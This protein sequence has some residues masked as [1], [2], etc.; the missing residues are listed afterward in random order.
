MQRS[1][2]LSLVAVVALAAGAAGLTL[3]LA[4]PAEG[5]APEP[6]FTGDAAQ[7]QADR[8]LRK[9]K[10][11]M[12]RKVGAGRLRPL[13]FKTKVLGEA[14]VAPVLQREKTPE[15]PPPQGSRLLIVTWDTVRADHVSSYG[16]FRETTPSFDALAAQ[17]VLFEN[18]I[19]PQS[20]TLP[21]HVSMFTGVH[22]DE[23][24]ITGNSASGARRFV[25]PDDL[26]PLARHLTDAGYAT[27]AFV[28]SAPVKQ[29]SG[30]AEGF[31]A[32]GEPRRRF[33]YASNTTQAATSWIADAAEDRPFFLWVHYYDPHAPYRT[34]PGYADVFPKESI[35]PWLEQRGLAEG[36][37]LA[38]R[39][40]N[41]NAY[42]AEIRY[43][44]DQLPVLLAALEARGWSDTIVLVAGDHGEGLD[45]HGHAEHGLVWSEQ[46]AAPLALRAPGL[47]P[48]RISTL[49]TAQD[50]L[51]M[52]AAVGDFPNEEQFTRQST[53][54]NV[55]EDRSDQPVLSR[56]SRRQLT[57]LKH[58]GDQVMAWS[59]NTPAYQFIYREDGNHSLFDRTADPFALTDI[60]SSNP[61]VVA[62]LTAQVESQ[63]A[64][65]AEKAAALGA[66]KT[67]PIS[68]ETVE[69]LKA[70]G[71]LD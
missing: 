21:T 58:G 41:I 28:S 70:L 15:G 60:A 34:P 10:K 19:V 13:K 24:G 18:Y 7:K 49:T 52:L 65:H 25:A 30:I 4:P 51:P 27:A 12:L 46:L 45:Q 16:Y 35:K 20:T 8:R 54:R 26:H 33:R 63:R 56:T 64:Q 57:K 37:D 6:V 69:D 17:G 11:P 38:K 66:G 3:F 59:L 43:V 61:A 31:Q 22:P 32:W 1:T 68:A 14:T 47:A 29:Y 42:D 48:E 2:L 9:L 53:G 44:D 36:K 23:H 62:R 71:Y 55:L 67:E 5:P 50:L 40:A 39:V